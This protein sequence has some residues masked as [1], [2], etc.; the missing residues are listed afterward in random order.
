MIER[1]YIEKFRSFFE[2]FEH[3]L[4]KISAKEDLDFLIEISNNF[5]EKNRDFIMEYPSLEYFS[6]NKFSKEDLFKRYKWKKINIYFHIPFCQN[7]CTYCNFNIVIWNK[8]KELFETLYIKKI[9]SEIQNFLKINE[10]FSIETIFIWWWTPSYLSE[11]SLE[12]LLKI[13]QTNLK[14]FFSKNI[15]YNI[16]ANPDSLSL[17]K[18]KLLAKYNINR[19]SL[20][21]QTFSEKTLKK[22]GRLYDKNTVFEVLKN[23]KKNNIDNI[24]IDMLYWLPDSEKEEMQNDLEIVSNLPVSH[25]TY[26]PM[27]YYDNAILNKSWNKKD[28]IK[29]I[30]WFYWEITKK[31]EINWF[32]QYWR[33]YFCKK[34]LTHKYQSN[35]VQNKLFIWFWNSARSFNWKYSFINYQNIS[36]YI[37]NSCTIEKSF[38]YTKED[39]VRRKF[40][41]WV[42]H[43]KIKKINL[44]KFD[45]F[46][47]K[48]K[49]LQEIWFIRFENNIYHITNL[50]IKYQEFLIHYFI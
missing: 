9:E 6:E 4:N 13:I 38:F 48:I 8:N 37:K 7:K 14:A 17:N 10:H 26:Y 27:Y 24:N 5:I 41:L 44:K 33:E 34:K 31:L 29:E 25:I 40:V 20:W 3:Q 15:E 30:Y 23:L 35:Y 16:E 12:N 2:K 32:K 43:N 36:E 42:R 47:K 22:V 21:V 28:N 49:I 45:L 39:L 50:W 46:E 19:V 1:N 11:K 18:I